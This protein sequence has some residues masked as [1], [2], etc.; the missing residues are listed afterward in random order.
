MA[1]NL[2]EPKAI[3]KIFNFEGVRRVDQLVQDGIIEPTLVKENGRSVRRYDLIPTVMLYIRYLQTKANS[4]EKNMGS[5]V[6]LSEEKLKEEIRYKKA[7]ADKLV[8]ELRELNG[9]MHRAEDVKKVFTDHAQVVRAMFLA[10]PGVLAVDCADA[11]TPKEAERII[12]RTV[13]DDLKL[14]EQYQYDSEEFRT[15]VKEREQW[16]SDEYEPDEEEEPV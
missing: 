5:S 16:I 14:L 4:K 15:L 9:Q 6:E 8:L 11:A 7:K 2:V 10:L 12:R 3:A 13:L 1:E